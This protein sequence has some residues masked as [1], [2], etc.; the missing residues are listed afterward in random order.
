MG[1]E[2]EGADNEVEREGADCGG[3]AGAGGAGAVGEG[4][5]GASGPLS[6]LGLRPRCFFGEGSSAGSGGGG[7]SMAGDLVRPRFLGEVLP[8]PGR[9]GTGTLGTRGISRLEKLVVLGVGGGLLG[10][11]SNAGGLL[12]TAGATRA[13]QAEVDTFAAGGVG[14]PATAVTSF[15]AFAF[16]FALADFFVLGA[17]ANAAAGADAA[18][19]EGAGADAATEAGAALEEAFF[20]EDLTLGGA[21]VPAAAGAA[22]ADD[23]AF[24]EPAGWA[25]SAGESD[26]GAFGN[27]SAGKP[28]SVRRPFSVSSMFASCQSTCTVLVRRVFVKYSYEYVGA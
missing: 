6:C 14:V 21:P 9:C 19:E 4:A 1:E 28:I 15:E 2:S 13:A 10:C 11:G 22:D 12:A 24:D 7:S 3:A 16:A 27:G 25:F 8:I 23:A 20:L 17:G 18:T 5:A 26:E